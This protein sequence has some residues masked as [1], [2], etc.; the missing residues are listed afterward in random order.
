MSDT[1]ENNS[2]NNYIFETFES[3]EIA[4]NNT[5]PSFANGL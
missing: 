3:D 4:K 1:L 2:S 5:E